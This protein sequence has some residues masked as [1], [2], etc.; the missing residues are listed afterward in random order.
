MPYTVFKL[1]ILSIIMLATSGKNSSLPS[2]GTDDPKAP[3]IKHGS[4]D[5]TQREKEI[6]Q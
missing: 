4:H 2:I 3:M 1:D 5:Q 6:A